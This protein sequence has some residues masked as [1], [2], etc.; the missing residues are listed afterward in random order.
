MTDRICWHCGAGTDTPQIEFEY[1]H[2][3]RIFYKMF[4]RMG[5]VVTYKELISG[6]ASVAHSYIGKIKKSLQGSGYEV[7]NVPTR[8]YILRKIDGTDQQAVD[9]HAD[10]R[11]RKPS[12]DVLS[13][14]RRSSHSSQ[15]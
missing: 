13:P 6:R 4:R 5:Q 3:R 9:V 15:Q 2:L 14:Q 11:G 7:I 1:P 10:G 8:G 12:V